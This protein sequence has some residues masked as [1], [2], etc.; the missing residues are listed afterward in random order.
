LGRRAR[1]EAKELT[2]VRKLVPGVQQDPEEFAIREGRS[3]PKKNCSEEADMRDG[4][5][6]RIDDKLTCGGATKELVNN[7]KPRVNSRTSNN[8]VV[9][10]VCL[11]GAP[12]L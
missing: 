9:P 10:V 12:R 4:G 6:E 5:G 2:T 8:F 11:M 1:L 3:D 7:L